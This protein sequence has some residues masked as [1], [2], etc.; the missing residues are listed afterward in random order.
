MNFFT[1][2]TGLPVLPG[3]S[4]EKIDT[5]ELS[6]L[7]TLKPTLERFREVIEQREQNILAGTE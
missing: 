4:E 7:G 3:I 2:A 1:L 6:N 5:K